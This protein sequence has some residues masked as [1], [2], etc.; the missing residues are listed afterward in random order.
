MNLTFDDKMKFFFI[1]FI[2][3]KKLSNFLVSIKAIRTFL[4]AEKIFIICHVDNLLVF[5]LTEEIIR[6]LLNELSGIL[7]I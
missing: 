4:K 6:G 7:K 3:N 1:I 2:L 5:S